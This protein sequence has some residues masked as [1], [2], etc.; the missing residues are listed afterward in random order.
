VARG[1][2]P[3]VVSAHGPDVAGRGR[4]RWSGDQGDQCDQGYRGNR[5]NRGYRGDRGTQR[6]SAL[7]NCSLFMED[8]PSMLRFFASS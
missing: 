8:R 3:A 2:H 4:W 5:G 6:P 7:S 1:L